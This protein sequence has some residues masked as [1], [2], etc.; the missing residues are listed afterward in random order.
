LRNESALPREVHVDIKDELAI[1]VL[2]PRTWFISFRQQFKSN[3]YIVHL[4]LDGVSPKGYSI[5]LV[6]EIGFRDRLRNSDTVL[7]IQDH[8]I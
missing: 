2:V 7:V 8:I 5:L 1:N 6:D 3:S 4:L